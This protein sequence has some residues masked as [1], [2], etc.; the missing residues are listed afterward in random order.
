[1][2]D[3]D[4]LEQYATFAADVSWPKL[5]R[6]YKRKYATREEAKAAR[7]AKR[8]N[9]RKKAR[10]RETPEQRAIRLAKVNEWARAQGIKVRA[11]TKWAKVADERRACADIA[12][13]MGRP[14]IAAAIRARGEI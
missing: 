11:K 8:N 12:V 4:D 9:L 14:D 1:M 13:S 7:N 10:E 2:S 3:I 6:I 5:K